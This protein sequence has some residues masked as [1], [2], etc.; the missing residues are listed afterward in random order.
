MYNELELPQNVFDSISFSR[1]T[2]EALL[3][4]MKAAGGELIP[5]LSRSLPKRVQRRTTEL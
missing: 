5:L 3:E 2:G 1:A 4:G